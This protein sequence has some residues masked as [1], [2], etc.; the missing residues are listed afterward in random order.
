MLD[1]E[2]Q[3]FMVNIDGKK[4]LVKIVVDQ[5]YLAI[6]WDTLLSPA[7]VMQLINKI[8][9]EIAAMILSSQ[10]MKQYVQNR[11]HIHCNMRQRLRC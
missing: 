1:Y 11:Y 6:Y 3:E 7:Q 2:E 4:V 5:G 10:T 9:A 8:I